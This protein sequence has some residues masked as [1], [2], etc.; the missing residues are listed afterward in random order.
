VFTGAGVSTVRAV[1]MFSAVSL[2]SIFYRDKDALSYTA[3]AA[4][5]LLVYEPLYLW[6]SGFLYSFTAVFGLITLSPS[7]ARCFDAIR[8]KFPQSKKLL[9]RKLIKNSIAQVLAAGIATLPVTMYFY[10]TISV[11]GVISNLIVLPSVFLLV[12]S[13]LIICLLGSAAAPFAILAGLLLSFYELLGRLLLL[14]PFSRLFTGRPKLPWIAAAYA[15]MLLFARMLWLDGAWR[16]RGRAALGIATAAFIA[17]A[18]VFSLLPKGFSVTMLDVGQGDCTVC[19]YNGL[20]IVIDGGGRAEYYGNSTGVNVLIPYLR[21]K[22]VTSVDMAFVSH[23]DADHVIGVIE[24]LDCFSVKA[25]YLSC[26]TSTDEPLYRLLAKS[27]ENSGAELYFIKSGDGFKA[28]ELEISCL[29]PFESSPAKDTNEQSMVL[30]LSYKTVDFL[31]TG[32]APASVERELIKDFGQ[33]LD[34]EVYKLGHH[35]SKYSNS[36]EFLEIVS[37]EFAFAGAGRHNSYGHPSQRVRDTLDELNIPL[38]DTADNG[39]IIITSDGKDIRVRVMAG[40]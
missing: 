30:K 34:C 24:L 17:A 27:L 13:G 15:D 5:I 12:I 32:D 23:I 16:K 36:A 21:Y 29:Y 39:A 1:L 22:G 19:E 2:S 37:P 26:T 6:D 3:L 31:F 14:I 7:I 20:T 40:K 8:E 9:D 4:L 11:I 33:E 10:G 35:G 38:Y 28:G 25:V 18:A